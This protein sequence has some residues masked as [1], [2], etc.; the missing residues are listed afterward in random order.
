MPGTKKSE[1]KYNLI[2]D[3][4]QQLL[5]EKKIQN[6]SVSEIAQKAG[7]GKGS[8]YYYF[9][10]KEAILDALIERSYEK[11]LLTAKNL[12]AQTEI[13]PFARMAMLFQ[14]C[15]NSSTAFVKQNDK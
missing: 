15:Q 6:I 10:S 7:I 9:P 4:L 3:A 12:A 14:A 8:I 5:E 11:P 13:S 2:L 1:K